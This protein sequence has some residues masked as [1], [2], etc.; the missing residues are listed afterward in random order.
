MNL[1]A[2]NC[3]VLVAGGGLAGVCASIAAARHGARVILV[4]DRSRLGGNS[5]SEIRMHVVGADSHGQRPNW[6]E[7][8]LIEE[9]RIEDAVRNP[10][11]SF[12]LWDLLLYEKCIAEANLTLLL[13]TTLYSVARQENRIEE[14]LARCD[15][16][17]HIY[18]IGAS[19]YCDCTGDSRLALEAGAGY[20]MGREAS[21]EFGESLAPPEADSH[22]QGSS[23]LFTAKRHG[24][25][26]TFRPPRW[27]RK[28]TREQLRFRAPGEE[29]WEYG[30]WW[31]ELGGMYNT[32]HEN[33][34]LRFELLAVVLGVWDYLK[35]SGEYPS[36]ENWALET[37]G[38]IPGKRESRR[39]M[40]EVIQTQTMLD[41]GWREMT[42]GVAIGGWNFDDHPPEGFNAPDVPPFTSVPL[43]E[44][45][46]IS[47][48]ALYSKDVVNLM[49][50]GRNI[51][52]T[53]VAFSSARVM[54]TCACTGQA[55]GTTAAICAR[56]NRLPGEIRNDPV[57]LRRLQQTLLQDDQSIRGVI[58]LDPRDRARKAEA[59]ASSA[60]EGSLP[61]NVLSGRTRDPDGSYANRW[62]AVMPN[63][64][65]SE[66]PWI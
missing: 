30:Y 44:P 61:G 26:T 9:L 38:M 25:P 63:A 2:L 47:L 58:S 4:Q 35:N 17:E 5:S 59:F 33:E 43:A 6:R 1:V 18:R 34:R 12:E 49:M 3:D 41:G 56:R 31:I 28:I 50:A 65:A 42:D 23:I 57:H 15:K 27:A 37:V 66:G 21:A 64:Q 14:I 16:T 45:Y 7:G 62:V 32:I 24:R 13:D 29:S 46:N 22:T 19:I 40:G 60:I 53:H 54:A 20:R 39:V 48:G 8:G 11:R 51:S 10:H 52:N 55:V 36:S